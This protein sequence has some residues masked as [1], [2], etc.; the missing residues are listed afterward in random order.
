MDIVLKKIN[1]NST[2]KTERLRGL[3]P[4]TLMYLQI[5][6]NVLFFVFNFDNY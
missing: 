6:E 4:N 1:K 3:V 5:I 2:H